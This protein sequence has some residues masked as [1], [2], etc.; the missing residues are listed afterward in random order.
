MDYKLIKELMETYPDESCL[1]MNYYTGFWPVWWLREDKEIVLPISWKLATPDKT[2]NPSIIFIGLGPSYSD[3][4]GTKASCGN[5][6]Y[7][8]F[9]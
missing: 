9:K 8:V 4:R 7:T 1:L 3:V 6:H 5:L 2:W